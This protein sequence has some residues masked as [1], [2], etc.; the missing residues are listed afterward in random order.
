MKGYESELFEPVKLFLEGLGYKVYAEVKNCDVV[1]QKGEELIA[2][3]M[4]KSFNVKLLYQMCERK[5][6]FSKVYAVIPTPQ[7]FRSKN[8]RY[9]TNILKKLGFGLITVSES[10]GRFTQIVLFAEEENKGKNNKKIA[11]LKKELSG[12]N[13]DTNVGGTVGKKLITAYRERSVCVLCHAENNEG[14]VK[15][16][17]L[18]KEYSAVVRSNYYN[19]FKKEDRGVYTLTEEARAFLSGDEFENVIQYYRKEANVCLK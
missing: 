12:R 3:E 6:I 14:R 17:Y 11:S 18:K 16:R 13:C 10:E 5:E 9:M 7:S 1:A 2:L 8:V 19:W 4:K 15:T